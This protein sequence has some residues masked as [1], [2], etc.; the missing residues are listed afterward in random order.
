MEKKRTGVFLVF[1]EGH[2]VHPGNITFMTTSEPK[3]FS[4]API[5]NTIILVVRTSTHGF[6]E[7]SLSADNTDPHHLSAELCPNGLVLFWGYSTFFSHLAI[8]YWACYI[9]SILIFIAPK[10]MLHLHTDISKM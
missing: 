9:Y 5:P 8:L 1:L 3:Y 2:Q 6:W 10:K 7:N 4:K